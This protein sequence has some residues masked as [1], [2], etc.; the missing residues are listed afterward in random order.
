MPQGSVFFE[1]PAHGLV[2]AFGNALKE[3]FDGGRTWRRP[4][5]AP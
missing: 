1:T 4:I 2:A 3:T 5:L